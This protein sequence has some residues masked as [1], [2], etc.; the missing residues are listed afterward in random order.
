M[1]CMNSE[2]IIETLRLHQPEL[3]WLGVE[4]L[5]LFGSMVRGEAGEGSDID[6]AATYDDA[7]VK[8][9][10]DLGGVAAAI[11]TYLGT[12]NF[13][14]ADERHLHPHV[15]RGFLQNHVRIF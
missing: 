5:A 7:V 12:D 13:D 9:L 4:S 1:D 15:R 14:L 2:Q 3:Q 8:S 6:L 11:E 10:F